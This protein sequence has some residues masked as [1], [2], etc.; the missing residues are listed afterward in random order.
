[1]WR[2]DFPAF[3]WLPLR[4]TLGLTKP[5]QKIFGQEFAGKVESVG[6]QV[7]TFKIS[8]KVFGNTGF[9]FGARAEYKAV[10]AKDAIALS[11]AN[12]S[13]EEAACVPTGG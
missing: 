4:L 10:P 13:F 1:M 5:R 7:A 3:M 2:F 12:A 11:P 6:V 9:G 8:D